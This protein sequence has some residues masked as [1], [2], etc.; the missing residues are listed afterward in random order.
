[1]PLRI[2]TKTEQTNTTFD[3][4]HRI[5]IHTNFI[6]GDMRHI[7]DNGRRSIRSRVTLGETKL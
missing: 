2:G 1:L 5:T 7:T 4:I 3:E 6:L